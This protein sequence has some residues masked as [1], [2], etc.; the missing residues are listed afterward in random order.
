MRIELRD[1]DNQ[2]IYEL[3][4]D[5]LTLAQLHVGSGM[6]IHVIDILDSSISSEDC[7]DVAFK[8]NEEDYDQRDGICLILIHMKKLPICYH[9]TFQWEVEYFLNNQNCFGTL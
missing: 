9:V 1:K 8:Y 2:L 6:K 3:T 5:N 4:D 7:P